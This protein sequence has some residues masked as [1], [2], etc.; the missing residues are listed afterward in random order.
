M[1]TEK[2]WENIF[3]LAPATVNLPT[4]RKCRC[5]NENCKRAKK[6]RC[7]CACHAEN[8]GI[9]QRR[10]MPELDKLL[11]LDRPDIEFPVEPPSPEELATW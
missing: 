7:V 1:T 4:A 8:H 6:I 2:N 5:G 10:G 3:A 11:G 9:E